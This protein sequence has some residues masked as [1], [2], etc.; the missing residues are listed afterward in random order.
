MSR[1][2]LFGRPWVLFDAANKDHR[3]S[4]HNFQVTGS[5]GACPWRFVVPDDRGDLITV[6]HRNLLEY[7]TQKEFGAGKKVDLE[8][9]G[10][11]NQDKLKN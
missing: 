2:S 6:I 1:L 3:A 7:Y 4:Y 5:W 8:A 10:G 11:Y 9:K